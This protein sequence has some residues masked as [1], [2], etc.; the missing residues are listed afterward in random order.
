MFYIN[1][2]MG[3]FKDLLGFC[4]AGGGWGFHTPTRPRPRPPWDIWAERMTILIKLSGYGWPRR[5]AC[6][7]RIAL[8]SGRGPALSGIGAKRVARPR[9]G[10]DLAVVHAFAVQNGGPVFGDTGGAGGGVFGLGEMQQVAA[11][12]SGG[13]R[14]EG[15][16]QIGVFVEGGDKFVGIGQIIFTEND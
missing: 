12:A 2:L 15:Q 9:Q 3:D 10:A 16:R 7:V 11:S 1:V 5:R 4:G 13:E 14:V 8:G 6:R